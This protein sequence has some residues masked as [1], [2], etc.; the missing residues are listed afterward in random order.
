[1]SEVTAEIHNHGSWGRHLTIKVPAD[2]LEE[3][4][5]KAAKRLASQVRMPGFRK[6]KVPAQVLEKKFGG[7][8]E[9]EMLDKVMG[10]AYREVIEREGLQP[11]SQAA[12]ENVDY[13]PGSDLTFDVHFE[14]RP[15]IELNRLGG[16]TVRRPAGEIGEEAV[17]R[18]VQRLREE[19]AAWQPIEPGQ[20]LVNGDMA[21]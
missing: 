20:A 4:R 18:V 10:A 8:V 19:H 21:T 14:V 15:E 16:F 17:D 7:A 5:G 6:G 3:E 9:Q 12:I 13:K 2:R 11:I 1:M